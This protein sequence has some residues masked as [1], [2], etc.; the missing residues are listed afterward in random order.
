MA[1]E[2]GSSSESSSSSG[3]AASQPQGDKSEGA[4]QEEVQ[5]SH[6]SVQT[7]SSESA[8][9][10]V[11]PALGTPADE[12]KYG[13]GGKVEEMKSPK[14]SQAGGDR[15]KVFASPLARKIALEKGIPLA[16]VK[17]TGPEGRITKVSPGS[18]VS[19]PGPSLILSIAF[20]WIVGRRVLQAHL[21]PRPRRLVIIFQ[22]LFFEIYLG[23]PCVVIGRV[24]R[25]SREQ[26]EEDHRTEVV[27]EQDPG[28]SLLRHRRGQHG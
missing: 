13:S 18:K 22:L 1:Q 24:R 7:T 23:S 3:P 17:G 5:G 28:A 12:R 10:D 27:G 19:E 15:K 26:H 21:F 11:T 20:M 2:G 8:K 6:E 16:Q 14:E 4:K 9:K 25:R